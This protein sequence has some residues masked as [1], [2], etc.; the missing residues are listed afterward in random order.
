MKLKHFDS[1]SSKTIFKLTGVFFLI[2]IV[3]S[4]NL[5][6][7]I[8]RETP[9]ISIIRLHDIN[10]FSVALSIV[11]TVSIIIGLI[12]YNYFYV[13]TSLITLI[14]LLLFD[15]MKWQPWVYIYTIALTLCTVEKIFKE[16]DVLFLIKFVLATVYFWAGIHK[17][18]PSYTA[19]MQNFS[20]IFLNN[21]FLFKAIPFIEVAMGILLFFGP[22]TKVLKNVYIIFHCFIIVFI[23]IVGKV[24]DVIIPW[25]IYD[26][27]Y[28]TTIS[29]REV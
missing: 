15:R 16:K 3:L 2:D 5:W 20:Y 17:F 7:K 9:Y 6:F 4:F 27:P 28:R 24:Y 29:K 12:K 25:N 10:Y 22:I 26:L 23:L 11:F 21:M 18:S 19:G 14:L 1:L 8:Y 13:L